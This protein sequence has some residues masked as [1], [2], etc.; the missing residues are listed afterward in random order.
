MIVPVWV[1]SWE[2]PSLEILTYPLLDSQSN[3]TFILDDTAKALNLKGYRVNLS[4][5]TMTRKILTL[6]A[7]RFLV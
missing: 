2:N 6:A 4:L 3:T 1:S 7:E 5:S